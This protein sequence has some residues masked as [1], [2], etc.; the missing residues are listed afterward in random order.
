[1][2]GESHA[3]EAARANVNEMLCFCY[4][5]DDEKQKMARYIIAMIYCLQREHT[6]IHLKIQAKMF[7]RISK[8]G[9]LKFH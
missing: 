2:H 3:E 8:N 5:T 1:M 7:N 6:L 9:W 4:A